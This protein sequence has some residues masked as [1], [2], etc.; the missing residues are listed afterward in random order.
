MTLPEDPAAT[1]RPRLAS[2]FRH[3]N[4]R[5]FFSGQIF[6]LMGD[7]MQTI[8]QS[9]LVFRLTGSTLDLG[10]IAFL[11]QGQ[12]LFFA[13]IGGTLADRFDRRK[14][15]L[16]AQIVF[17]VLAAILTVLTFTGAVEVWHVAVLAFLKGMFNAIEIPTR[18][19]FTVEM[20]GRGDM[21]NAIALN[22]VMFNAARIVGPGV[23]GLVIAAF[24]EAWCFAANTLTYGCVITSLLLMRVPAA[25][26]AAERRHPFAEL[27]EGFLY[28]RHHRVIR[29]GLIAL[30]IS[31]FAGGPYLTMMPVFASEVLGQG[32]R[33]YGFLMT[34]VGAGALCGAVAM[35]FLSVA[36]LAHAPVLAAMLFGAGLV[37]LSFVDVFW[38]ALCVIPPMAF[39]LMLQGS[40]TNAIL[41]HA[42]ADHMRGRVMAYYTMAFL[43]MIPLGSL[44]AG[45]LADE[46]GV[47]LTYRIGGAIVLAAGALGWVVRRR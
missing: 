34:A 32:S 46:I 42:V 43:G 30:A 40:S 14:L 25:A 18:Q 16:L 4:Y 44:F 21:Q 28:V 29:L 41:Q 24:G 6:S 15:I 12:V 2:V 33:E 7:W 13:A 38:L 10:M 31:S 5:L 27:K 35:S 37:A 9:W 23:A 17:M 45:M 20:V 26:R 19:A 36:R 39:M 11:Q 8:G 47:P 3:R 22:A 1:T